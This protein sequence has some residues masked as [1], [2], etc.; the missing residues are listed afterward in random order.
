[1]WM[2]RRFLVLALSFA[3]L[4]CGAFAQQTVT[5]GNA[6]VALNGPWKFHTGDNMAWAQPD[7]DDS[8]WD[9]MDLTLPSGS[10]D[11][12][13]GAG[14]WV[15]GWTLRG[16]KDLSGYAW[17]RLRV[18]IQNGQSAL[19]LKM[20]E[21]VDDAYQV[22]VNGQLLGQF[23]R[24]T[25]R[26]VTF[27]T[28]QPLVVS[29]PATLHN[30]ATTIA[31]RMW[32]S[33]DTPYNQEGAGGLHQPPV[34]GQASVVQ[35]LTDLYW[36]HLEHLSLIA[37]LSVAVNL[38]ALLVAFALFWLDRSELAYLWLGLQ[39]TQ[40][41]LFG[42]FG[43][44]EAYTTWIS[45]TAT[46]LL[47][48]ALLAPL[49]NGLVL[50]FW[51]TWFRTPRIRLLRRVVWSIVVLQGIAV[52]MTRAPLYGD[53]VP[54]HANVWLRPLIG[55]LEVLLALL[56]LRVTYL[57]FR[58]DRVE[59]LLALPP[60]LLVIVSWYGAPALVALHV[61]TY[62]YLFGMA[63]PL[64][65][66]ATYV[67][68]AIVTVLMLRRF[69]RSQREREHWKLEIEQARQ[70]QQ[71]LI[72]DTLPSIPGFHLESDFRPAQRVG[73]DFFQIIEAPGESLLI[74]LGDVTGHGLKAAMMVSLIVGAIRTETAH[75]N[76][77]LTLLRALNQR[78]YGRGDVFA[79]C[80]AL[81]IDPQGNVELANAGHLP[82]YLNGEEMEMAGALPLGM[83]ADAEFS[84]MSFLLKPGDTLLMMTDGVAEAQDAQGQQF[85]FDRIARMAQQTVS[86][87]EIASAAQAFGQ[88]DDITV[89]RVVRERADASTVAGAEFAE[90][91]APNA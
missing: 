67:A 52:A 10:Y 7:Y 89:L 4:L 73:G 49:G 28:T 91:I 56:L 18:N 34:L 61:Q 9:K 48:G 40:S 70:V 5:L 1:M 21:L 51:A 72:P 35:A 37:S 55:I 80:F 33:A 78:L 32:M 27:Y 84:T 77:P 3:C 24:F 8:A 13:S 20:P 45:G 36:Y 74:V 65:L 75:G 82:P 25:P 41:L 29:L 88:Q 76:D 43:V 90:V 66:V 14:G 86:A 16:Y 60:V 63:F 12:N 53:V 47:M 44:I 71:V 64:P 38:L 62:F 17:Y 83:V 19:A 11:P 58:K 79:T 30:G 23:G 85:G 87:A 59:G 39:C 22:Y 50:I 42:A 26:G 57:G 31:V 54:V 46:N 69:L 81:R 15:P 68:L 6:T 2:F